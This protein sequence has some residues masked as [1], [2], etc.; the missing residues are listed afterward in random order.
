[1]SKKV[2][3]IYVDDE[4]VNVMLFEINFPLTL[5]SIRVVVGLRGLELLDKHPDV[6]VVISDMKM[7]KMNGIEFIKIAKERYPEKKFYILTGFEITEEIQ[8]ALQSG[9]IQKYFRKPFDIHEIE[10]TIKEHCDLQE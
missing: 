7:P 9:L 10:N 6:K 1:M 5:K 4:E 8:D 2:K 3:I